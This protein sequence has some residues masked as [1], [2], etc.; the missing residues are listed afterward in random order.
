VEVSENEKTIW[1][2][3]TGGLILEDDNAIGIFFDAEVVGVTGDCDCTYIVNY[4][5]VKGRIGCVQEPNFF[6]DDE[7]RIISN[8]PDCNCPP[9]SEGLK[10][11][12][13]GMPGEKLVYTTSVFDP[14]GDQVSFMIDWGDGTAKVW[15]GPYGNLEVVSVDHIFASEG[16][17][18]VKVKAKDEHD[19]K[20]TWVSTIV[21]TI[22]KEEEPEDK[23]EISIPNMF[24]LT[25]VAASI[26]NAGDAAVTDVDWTFTISGGLFGKTIENDGTIASLAKSAS[27]VIVSDDVKFTFGTRTID[28]VAKVGSESFSETFSCFV[29]GRFILIS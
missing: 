9:Y 8:C 24:Y 7:I 15:D 13:E 3:S 29:L 19:L 5:Y 27:T 17:Y 22:T 18:Q 6:M 11:P 25:N 4:A 10:G 26:K 12:S 14:D 20:S 28:I 1:F 2:N 16:V 21:V 23:L